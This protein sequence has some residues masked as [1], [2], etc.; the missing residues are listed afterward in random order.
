MFAGPELLFDE[1]VPGPADLASLSQTPGVQR[2]E[3]LHYQ[4]QTHLRLV[5]SHWS[6]TYNTALSLVET[7][8]S[9]AGAI[10]LMP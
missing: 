10:N 9:D 1:V 7:F 4:A 6:R 3:H 8:P 5:H 2:Q